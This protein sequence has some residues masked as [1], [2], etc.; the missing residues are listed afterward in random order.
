LDINS[1]SEKDLTIFGQEV[2][3]AVLQGTFLKSKLRGTFK[4]S[5][6]KMY[7]NMIFMDVQTI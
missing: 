7:L 4:N 1:I 5:K 6:E 2:I 3:T